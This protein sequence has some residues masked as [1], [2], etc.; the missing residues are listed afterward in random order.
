MVFANKI[1]NLNFRKKKRR[2]QARI[3]RVLGPFF[4]PFFGPNT[5]YYLSRERNFLFSRFSDTFPGEQ[6]AFGEIRVFIGD[7]VIVLL[8]IGSRA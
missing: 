8:V 6:Q 1:R 7:V 3:Q 5:L 2:K 4:K